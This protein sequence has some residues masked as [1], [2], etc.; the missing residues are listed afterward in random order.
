LT[1]SSF[2]PTT[3]VAELGSVTAP[4]TYLLTAGNGLLFAIADVTLGA[5]G[6][7]G[8]IGATGPQG[9]QGLMGLMGLQGVPGIQGP[10][11]PAGATGPAGPAGPTG[12]TGAIGPA[13]PAGPVGATGPAGPTGPTGAT[14][15]AGPVGPSGPTG[16]TGPT[17]ATGPAGGQ[18]WS[19][20]FLLPSLPAGPETILAP[21][22]GVG[23]GQNQTGEWAAT[24]ALSIPN[25]CTASGFTASEIGAANT[26]TAIV[27]LGQTATLATALQNQVYVAMGCNITANNGGLATCSDPGTSFFPAG[28]NVVAVFQNFY[29]GSDFSGAHVSVSWICQ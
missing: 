29:S 1:V 23:I 17:G 28:T 18:I 26:S 15:P 10:A 25:S 7:Q 20:N 4:G 22:S 24:V 19:A 21:A 5:V 3:I 27:R 16:P 8:P 2:T 6:P 12:A 14:G 9:P 13:G 11:G